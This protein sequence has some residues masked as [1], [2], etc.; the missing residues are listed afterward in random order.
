MG[1]SLCSLVWHATGHTALHGKHTELN[2][3][4]PPPLVCS[5]RHPCRELAGVRAS[6]ADEQAARQRVEGQLADVQSALAASSSK[7]ESSSA[8]VLPTAAWHCACDLCSGSGR[9][10]GFCCVAM[11]LPSRLCAL[12]PLQSLSWRPHLQ[13][14]TPSWQL[15]RRRNGAPSH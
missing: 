2:S 10:P 1:S 12:H 4:R 6:L 15:P 8:L 5:A 13:P 14:A 9:R 3:S 11:C 7:G